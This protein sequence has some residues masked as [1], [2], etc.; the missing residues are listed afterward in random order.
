ML[1][2]VITI[3]VVAL[4]TVVNTNCFAGCNCDD[5]VKRGGYCVNYVNSRIPIFPI[6]QDVAAIK[7][8]KN[9]EI[10]EVEK[11]DVA[12]FDLGAYWHVAYVEKVHVDQHGKATAVDVSEMNF[13]EQ[14]T[15]DDFRHKWGV[16][17]VSEWKRA[18]CCGVTK[19][20]D[21]TSIRENIELSSIHQIWSTEFFAFQN[22]K[23]SAGFPTL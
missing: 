14:L 6:P 9:K 16:T 23:Y 21:R 1:K 2:H 11:G 20:Y 15:Y 12:I 22:F 7:S 13:G 4:I 17:S 8:L 18:I 19:A 5:W 3:V 10:T